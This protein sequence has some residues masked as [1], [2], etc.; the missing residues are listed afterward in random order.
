MIS[1]LAFD[2]PHGR[3]IHGVP[4][5]RNTR[6]QGVAIDRPIVVV[7]LFGILALLP[8]QDAGQELD[9]LDGRP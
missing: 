6:V 8:F 5:V 1:S 2:V 4:R 3:V 7:V 9:V